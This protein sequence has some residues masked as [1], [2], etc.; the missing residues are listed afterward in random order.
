MSRNLD[1]GIW[2]TCEKCGKIGDDR[3]IPTVQFPDGS[4]RTLCEKCFKMEKNK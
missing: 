1:M 3:E 4:F 2:V